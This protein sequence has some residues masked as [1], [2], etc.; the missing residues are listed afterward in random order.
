MKGFKIDQAVS[1][2]M[3]VLTEYVCNYTL[4][5]CYSVV[6]CALLPESACPPVVIY[7]CNAEQ[8]K[9]EMRSTRENRR[10]WGTPLESSHGF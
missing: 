7:C 4:E 10:F 9:A 8:A 5:P 3:L 6:A 1:S 2:V